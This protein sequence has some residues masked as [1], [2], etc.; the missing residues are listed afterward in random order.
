MERTLKRI[1]CSKFQF[2]FTLFFMYCVG[3]IVGRC[4]KLVSLFSCNKIFF[5]FPP[6]V[7]DLEGAE[8]FS[9]TSGSILLPKMETAPDVKFLDIPPVA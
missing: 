1:F 2:Q 8:I 7:T 9:L 5:L 6:L 4:Q 3:G